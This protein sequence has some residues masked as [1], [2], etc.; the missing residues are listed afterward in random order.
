M[1]IETIGEPIRVLAD[2][3]GGAMQPLRF[4]WHGRT[5]RVEAVNGR[6]VD[7]Q[8]EAYCLHFS[9]QVGDETYRIH[10]SSVQVQWWLDDVIVGA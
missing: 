8:G 5:Y 2:C 9:V 3:S 7:R 6:W 1:N 4:R 10:F